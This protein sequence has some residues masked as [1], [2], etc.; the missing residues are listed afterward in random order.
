MSSTIFSST[1]RMKIVKGK[2]TGSSACRHTRHR[3]DPGWG[4]CFLFSLMPIFLFGVV[5]PNIHGGEG[6][7]HTQFSQTARQAAGNRPEY[8]S[9]RSS[10]RICHIFPKMDVPGLFFLLVDM[11]YLML[12]WKKLIYIYT[13][14]CAPLASRVK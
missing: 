1:G 4:T 2:V 14:V 8:L 10:Y 7:M 9:V 12:L 11:I 3:V 5:H 13:E 6:H